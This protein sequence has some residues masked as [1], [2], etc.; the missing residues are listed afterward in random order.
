M[1]GCDYKRLYVVFLILDWLQ[2]SHCFVLL[3][4]LVWIWWWIWIWTYIWCSMLGSYKKKFIKIYFGSFSILGSLI[5]TWNEAL[6]NGFFVAL[7]ML[8]FGLFLS[9]FL[10]LVCVCASGMHSWSRLCPLVVHV[11]VSLLPILPRIP[12]GV[13]LGWMLLVWSLQLFL[14]TKFGRHSL[15]T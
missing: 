13:P 8:Y 10:V 9:L 4:L 3:F 5:S 1:F 6:F 14:Q 2:T 7:G 15:M 11:G 12:T